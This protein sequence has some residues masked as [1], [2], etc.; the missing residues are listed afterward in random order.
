MK[1]YIK[2]YTADELKAQLGDNYPKGGYLYILKHGIGPGTIP[3]DVTV[4]KTKDLPNYY[5]AVWLDRFLTAE[6]LKQYD[7][8]S[9][10]DINKYLSRINYCQKNG[11]VVPCDD[12]K[13]STSVKAATKTP[14]FE[15]LRDEDGV[16]G[17]KL[18]NWYLMKIYSWGNSYTWYIFDEPRI[19]LYEYEKSKMG[20]V[21][22]GHEQG[23]V[24]NL[25][26]GKQILIDRYLAENGEGNVQAC[27]QVTATVK[28]HPK[29]PT[30]WNRVSEGDDENGNWTTISKELPNN[31]GYYWIDLYEDDNG[32]KYYEIQ[33]GYRTDDGSISDVS[34][35]TSK[36]FYRLGDAVK[37]AEDKIVRDYNQDIDACD[38]VMASTSPEDLG[39][40]PRQRTAADGKTWW[41]VFDTA[42][43]KYSTYTCFG[44][45]K[46]KKDCQYAIDH[47][48]YSRDINSAT[49]P[50]APDAKKSKLVREIIKRAKEIRDYFQ[51]HNNNLNRRQ[52]QILDDL[53][54]GIDNQSISAIREAIEN[55]K[56]NSKNMRSGQYD[57]IIDLYNDFNLAGGK[58]EGM[59][60]PESDDDNI[61]GCDSIQSST[62]PRYMANMVNASD[63]GYEQLAETDTNDMEWAESKYGACS[64]YGSDYRGLEDDFFTDDPSALVDWIWEHAAN[65]GY[66]EVSGPKDSI[67]LDPDDLAEQVDFGGIDEYEI[68]SQIDYL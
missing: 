6:E 10:T 45:Y 63:D 20:S 56:Y 21:G 60:Y 47:C 15:T 53:S 57:L 50:N 16:Y 40:E 31:D 65:G 51:Y 29:I 22:D 44:K 41:V 48:E 25:K 27:G 3:R 9:E 49:E 42:T 12:V 32:K 52:E 5:I 34:M 1:K 28:T 23:W 67:R 8:P 61:N 37:F 62:K 13:S 64:Y 55:L 26:E 36:Q 66:I 7:I 33:A 17:Y 18:G 35:L 46:T 14:K 30:G 24:H 11:D 54:D 19:S 39:L 59:G 43:G 68:M 38:K 2:S 58:F 4:V